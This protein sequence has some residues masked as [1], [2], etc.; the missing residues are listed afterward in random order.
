M[1][2]NGCVG[3]AII[4]VGHMGGDNLDDYVEMHTRGKRNKTMKSVHFVGLIALVMLVLSVAPVM[5]DSTTAAE[6]INGSVVQTLSIANNAPALVF[7]N[8]VQGMNERDNIGTLAVTSNFVPHWT[9][10]TV[11]ADGYG[12]MRSGAGAPVTGTYLTTKLQEYNYLAGSP[13]W[14]DVQGMT[15]GG[16]ASTTMQESFRQNVLITDVNGNYSTIVTYTIAAV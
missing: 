12:Y 14:Q 6:P 3:R 5:A 15:F 9:V 13:G 2:T 11:T 16:S 1:I 4:T 8:F 7:G 10:T